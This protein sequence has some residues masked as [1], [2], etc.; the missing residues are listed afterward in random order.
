MFKKILLSIA[1][2]GLVINLTSDIAVFNQNKKARITGDRVN[3]SYKVIQSI[4]S[5]RIA[6]LESQL[7][8]LPNEIIEKKVQ[9][10]NAIIQNSSSQKQQAEKISTLT[11]QELLTTH[12]GTSLDILSKMENVENFHLS[13]LLQDD[14]IS[15]SQAITLALLANLLDILL[16][17][18]FVSFYLYERK[19]NLKLQYSL[20]KTL[21]D[22]EKNNQKLNAALARK[23]IELKTAVHDLKNPLGS[24]RG[25]AELIS[26]EAEDKDSILKMSR[27]IQK[28][29]N[30][31][32]VIVN[33]LL[34]DEDEETSLKE[35]IS[36]LSCL[37]ETCNFLSPIAN[38]KNQKI[39]IESNLS[40]FKVFANKHQI[41]DV[42]FNVVGNALKF[43][44][45]NSIIS[46]ESRS[47]NGFREIRVSDAGPG[48]LAEDYPNLFK[49][50]A[51][52]S[53]KPTGNETSTGIGL[54]SAK[55]TLEIL[56]AK[57]TA[58]NGVN[59]GACVTISFPENTK[60]L[61]QYEAF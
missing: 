28:V 26:D 32:L 19:V 43:S 7:K 12:L 31:S 60:P 17:L 57:I 34:N 21:I 29:S 5:L 4:N 9:S 59:G 39:N 2:F 27:L 44:P 13:E 49:Y 37:K 55:Q 41:Q 56:N 20:A 50:G 61:N 51:K 35:N 33:E 14:E 25:F 42:F 6:L 23:K 30:R 58:T 47:A 15:N 22:V 46:V 24:I 36:V 8:K 53:A 11:L 1:V 52:L 18:I 16:I 45:E 10:L 38:K 40:E 48:F 3:H 54:Y